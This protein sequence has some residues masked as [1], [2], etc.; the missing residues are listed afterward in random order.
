MRHDRL[1]PGGRLFPRPANNVFGHYE[2][3]EELGRGAVGEVYKART[4]T[5][6]QRGKLVCLK[7]L[8]RR[9]LDVT[10]D[11][12]TRA[13]AIR[14]LQVEVEVLDE[15]EHPNIARVVEHGVLNDVC[16][17][18]F[19]LVE[20]ANLASVLAVCSKG[21]G[22]QLDHVYAIGLQVAQALSCAHE[23]GVLHRDVKPGNIMLGKDGQV[24]LVD[25]G[26]AKI[27]AADASY[28]SQVGTPPYWA[29]EQIS[30]LPLTP[31][32]DV[33]ALGLVM[34]EVAVGQAV[35]ES[36]GVDEFSESVIRN[37]REVDVE[38]L[39]VPED[40]RA[41]LRRC[42][43]VEPADRYPTAAGLAQDLVAAFECFP[44][45]QLGSM[46]KQADAAYTIRP[47]MRLTVFGVRSRS[48]KGSQGQNALATRRPW[49]AADTRFV[50][51][52]E[53]P[54]LVRK[55]LGL[56]SSRHL[57]VFE[58]LGRLAA[59][60]ASAQSMRPA[61]GEETSGAGGQLVAQVARQTTG[62]ALVGV[63]DP[64]RR[65]FHGKRIGAAVAAVTV[66]GGGVLLG[67]TWLSQGP[68]SVTLGSQG[69]EHTGQPPGLETLWAER[70]VAEPG[71][72]PGLFVAEAV[73][74]A[75]DGNIGQAS[76]GLTGIQAVRSPEDVLPPR[77]TVTPT[78]QVRAEKVAG[79][80]V[81]E[82]KSPSPMGTTGTEAD[83]QPNDE[84]EGEK[85]EASP[86]APTNARGKRAGGKSAQGG[87]LVSS[88]GGSSRSKAHEEH[89]ERSAQ[90]VVRKAPV[91]RVTIGLIPDGRVWVDG[92]EIGRA[93]VQIDLTR[94]RHRITGRLNNRERSR[95]VR[96]TQNPKPILIDFLHA[97]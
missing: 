31:A 45:S 86:L 40:L 1:R 71:T 29:P 96:I 19:E 57:S 18:A 80:P 68:A 17:V 60:A 63:S 97:E 88:D 54:R 43:A 32:V 22:L 12:V 3:L 85:P 11:Q 9:H 48:L 24:K 20:G 49:E 67:A 91:E 26:L 35:F 7:I 58:D 8:G 5:G 59:R 90:V 37:G 6:A 2:I 75:V 55:G 79:G 13:R 65:R 38:A 77:V 33:Y 52:S 4:L 81:Q 44:A 89:R 15:L 28:F 42:L 73:A 64:V 25:F 72:P 47:R 87:L 14:T 36:H 95:T 30:G 50:P 23:R 51:A 74:P 41:V 82:H 61:I 62:A 84:A 16:F 56:D 66:F 27:G 70:P 69:A 21:R 92:E 53:L 46:A 10:A 76:P 78:A 94:G 93:P 34:A 39:A 83:S